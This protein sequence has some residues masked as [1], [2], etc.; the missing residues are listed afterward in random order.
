MASL[1]NRF[2]KAVHS[3]QMD[4]LTTLLQEHPGGV[5]FLIS[6]LH[7]TDE[8]ELGRVLVGFRTASDVLD[9]ERRLDLARRLM[10]LLNEES[11]NNCPNAALALAAM[12]NCHPE[13]IL[14]HLPVLRVY[15]EDPSDYIGSACRKAIAQIKVAANLDE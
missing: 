14:P 10:W 13:A 7:A 5:R 15:A 6:G 12:A 11:G 3:G 2:T 8:I 9:E 1:K 4:A